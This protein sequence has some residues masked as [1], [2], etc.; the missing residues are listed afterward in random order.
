M[1]IF[2]IYNQLLSNAS[3][4]ML[5]RGLWM[6]TQT[7]QGRTGCQSIPAGDQT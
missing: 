7:A 5:K 6:D 3:E 2:K 4:V 1:S